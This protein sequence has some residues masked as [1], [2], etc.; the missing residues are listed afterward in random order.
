MKMGYFR[1]YLIAIATF[2][3]AAPAVAVE[4]IERTAVALYNLLAPI[5]KDT[6]DFRVAYDG[7]LVDIDRAPFDPSL[8]QSL[9]HESG[10]RTRAAMRG[11]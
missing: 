4:F 10:T 8:L 5:F 9:R 3:C 1:G 2:A 7:P 6:R 11:G